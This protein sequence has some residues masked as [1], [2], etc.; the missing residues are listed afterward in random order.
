MERRRLLAAAPACFAAVA[1]CAD[2]FGPAGEPSE[3]TDP[4]AGEA[5]TRTGTTLTVT[6]TSTDTSTGGEPDQSPKRLRLSSQAPTTLDVTI[7]IVSEP[8]GERVYDETRTFPPGHVLTIH[9][10]FERGVDYRLTI[11]IDG[12]TVFERLV[13]SYQAYELVIQSATAVTVGEKHET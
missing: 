5:T 4:D 13:R 12:E 2:L 11:R 6:T 1:G 9:N 8:D 10:L 3:P 7:V